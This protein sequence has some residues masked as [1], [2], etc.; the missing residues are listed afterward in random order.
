MGELVVKNSCRKRAV[1]YTSTLDDWCV[2]FRMDPPLAEAELVAS[3]ARGASRN[4]LPLGFR[5]LLRIHLNAAVSDADPAPPP[6]LLSTF[7]SAVRSRD[8]AATHGLWSKIKEYKSSGGEH[9]RWS[10]YSLQQHMKPLQITVDLLHFLLFIVQAPDL[11]WYLC[12]DYKQPD[13]CDWRSAINAMRARGCEEELAPLVAA[14]MDGL[15]YVKRVASPSSPTAFGDDLRDHE[16]VRQGWDLGPGTPADRSSWWHTVLRILYKGLQSAN[17]TVFQHVDGTHVATRFTMLGR[18]VLCSEVSTHPVVSILRLCCPL[19]HVIADAF[20]LAIS[21][22]NLRG[23]T[24]V[25]VATVLYADMLTTRC[26]TLSAAAIQLYRS[27]YDCNHPINIEGF[28]NHTQ[29]WDQSRWFPEL[30]KMW[31]SLLRTANGYAVVAMCTTKAGELRIPWSENEGDTRHP[32]E[33][34]SVLE[35]MVGAHAHDALVHGLLTPLVRVSLP[36]V[37][38]FPHKTHLV[39]WLVR[40]LDAQAL[41]A[42][43]LRL[44]DFVLRVVKYHDPARVWKFVAQRLV[45]KKKKRSAALRPKFQSAVSDAMWTLSRDTHRGGVRALLQTRGTLPEHLV[46]SE[47]LCTY[48]VCLGGG[49]KTDKACNYTTDFIGMFEHAKVVR[50]DFELFLT[51]GAF[52]GDMLVQAL[53]KA[54]ACQSAVAVEVLVSPPHNVRM[55]NDDQFT[56]HIVSALL[57]PAEGAA[58]IARDDFAKRTRVRR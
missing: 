48:V 13:G 44:P 35:G 10:V 37:L 51:S 16:A 14:L 17:C 3:L 57:A 52:T 4:P 49:M 36:A 50:R 9:F 12:V 6:A 34:V 18:A 28:R 5:R 43:C 38:D 47:V 42:T 31:A 56:H 53:K 24:M 40:R 45:R 46:T 23:G 20:E 25:E 30:E 19:V 39:E 54:S 1:S 11:V 22:G 26:P 2:I 32:D 29:S 15:L 58:S 27:L 7:A 33:F 41:D 8:A 55:P 21:V